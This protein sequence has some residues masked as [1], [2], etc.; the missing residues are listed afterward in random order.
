MIGDEETYKV[1]CRAMRT[2]ARD[3]LKNSDLVRAGGSEYLRFRCP[4]PV[5]PSLALS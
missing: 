4:E 1:I 3:R 5:E 2:C